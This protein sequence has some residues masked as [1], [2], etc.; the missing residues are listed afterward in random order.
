MALF[1]GSVIVGNQFQN[2]NGRSAIFVLSFFS[3]R[4]RLFLLSI[5]KFRIGNIKR[6]YNINVFTAMT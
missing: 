3:D 6:V 2:S 1:T 4:L 5:I